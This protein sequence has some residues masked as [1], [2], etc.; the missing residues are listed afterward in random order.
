[1]SGPETNRSD[2][3]ETYSNRFHEIFGFSLFGISRSIAKKGNNKIRLLIAALLLLAIILVNRER[4]IVMKVA[5]PL[6]R[7]SLHLFLAA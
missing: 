6:H 1:V 2:A 5:E 7:L 3:D 4:V